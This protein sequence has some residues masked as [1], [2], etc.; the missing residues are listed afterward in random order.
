MLEIQLQKGSPLMSS[1]N[2]IKF[3]ICTFSNT[4]YARG[5]ESIRH[6]AETAPGLNV[7]YKT[8][9]RAIKSG[10]ISYRTQ[11]R[12]ANAL[13][14]PLGYLHD[15]GNDDDI[16]CKSILLKLESNGAT[17]KELWEL[18]KFFHKYG[19]LGRVTLEMIAD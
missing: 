9:L 10:Y 4:V 6:F 8:I 13:H 17:K 16:A 19:L 7:S 2:K 1:K 3:D 12:L 14:C 11:F 15:Y 5:Y 18:S